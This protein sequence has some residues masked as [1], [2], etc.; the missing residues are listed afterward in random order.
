MLYSGHELDKLDVD[1]LNSNEPIY[2]INLDVAIP[3]LE[4]IMIYYA[5]GDIKN[6]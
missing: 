4:E 1:N 6:D 5:K 3:S 2:E